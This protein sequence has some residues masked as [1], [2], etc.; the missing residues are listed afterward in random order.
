MRERALVSPPPPAP[1]RGR[2]LRTCDPAHAAAEPPARFGRRVRA[3]AVADQVHV[4]G[5]VAQLGLRTDAESRPAGGW[6]CA[7]APGTG[8][9]GWGR[10]R[11]GNSGG[12]T[13]ARLGPQRCNSADQRP[14]R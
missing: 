8:T 9:G 5:A 6:G 4:L 10:T 13:P 11:A 1:R 7:P 12:A 14:P 2:A 3:Q